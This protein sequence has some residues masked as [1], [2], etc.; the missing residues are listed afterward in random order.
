MSKQ[1]TRK[2][3]LNRGKARLWL[4]GAI[5]SDNGFSHGDTWELVQEEGE[6]R[7]KAT[8]GGS[9]RIAG[10]PE[11]PIIDINSAAMLADFTPGQIVTLTVIRKGHIKVEG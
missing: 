4:E 2:I 5:L 1:Y 9:R 7:L 6:L 3:G 8:Q 11:R 10:K